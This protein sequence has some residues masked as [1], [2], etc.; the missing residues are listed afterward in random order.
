MCPSKTYA[1]KLF[2]NLQSF[3]QFLVCFQSFAEF[4]LHLVL[5]CILCC[6]IFTL[7]LIGTIQCVL[8]RSV[9]TGISIERAMQMPSLSYC[10]VVRLSVC[11]NLT[12]YENNTS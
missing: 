11:H 1:H 2:T 12:L 6:I 7:V 9:F 8:C 5:C 10:K 4:F 3:V